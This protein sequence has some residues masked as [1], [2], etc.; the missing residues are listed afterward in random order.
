MTSQTSAQILN[1]IAIGNYLIS[2]T[3]SLTPNADPLS[4]AQ[5]ILLAHDA[6]ELILA[7]LAASIGATFKDRHK[8]F[9]MDYVNAIEE[10][11]QLGIKLFFNELNEARIAFKHLGIPP[12]ANHF[13]DCVVKTRR[14]LDESCRAC[15]GQPLEEV[16]LEALIEDGD[17]RELYSHS[18]MVSRQGS[19]KESLESLA[20]AFQQALNAT[21]FAYVVR[22]GKPETEAALHLLGCGVDPS[23]FMSLQ[24]FLPSVELGDAI[25]WDTRDRGHPANWTRENVDY[26][27][28]AAL[29]VI[30]QIQHAQ[31]GA[32]AIPFEYVFEDVLS[33]K[34]DGVPLHSEMGG[35]YRVLFGEQSRKT[36]GTLKK[37][38]QISGHATPAFDFGPP[39]NWEE[40]SIETANIFVVSQ[41]KGDTL[42]ELERHT[43]IVVSS[44]LVELSYRVKN[45]P[46]IRERFPHLFPEGEPE[47]GE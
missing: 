1:R 7:G 6:S 5:A 26:C 11:K 44:D 8:T 38:Q 34:T 29:R 46:G 18:K 30:L 16:G 33:A 4:V 21:P 32:H 31:F 37:G 41:P 2:T 45:H 25:K 12:N 36:A 28:A 13:Y 22:V 23:T 15:L 19:F 27:L 42:G 24:E 43:E 9:L 47:A 39:K 40:T 20:L 3:G 10:R 35:M 17:A 14:H